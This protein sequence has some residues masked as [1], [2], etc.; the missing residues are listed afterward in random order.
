VQRLQTHIDH[1]TQQELRQQGHFLQLLPLLAE[2]CLRLKCQEC[3][4]LVKGQDVHRPSQVALVHA[5]E[6]LSVQQAHTLLIRAVRCR[7]E[8]PPE[9]HLLVGLN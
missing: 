9:R 6:A 8:R 7:L 4:S 2:A 5:A 1:R 3:V